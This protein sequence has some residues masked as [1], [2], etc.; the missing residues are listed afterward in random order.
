ML[1]NIK[2]V[3]SY[4]LLYVNIYLSVLLIKPVNLFIISILKYQ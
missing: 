2:R 3:N 1:T 4:E